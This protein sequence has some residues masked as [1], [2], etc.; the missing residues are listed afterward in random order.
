MTADFKGI[1]EELVKQRFSRS[2]KTYSANAHVQKHTAEKLISLLPGKNYN[3]ILEIGAGSGLLTE[4]IKKNLVFKKYTAVDIVPECRQYIDK[5]IPDNIFIPGNI[6]KIILKDSYDLIIS[7]AALQWCSN[8]AEQINRLKES[9]NQNG[10][11][12]A[13]IFGNSNF[14]EL[15]SVLN[16][17]DKMKTSLKGIEE[18]IKLYFDS[19]IDILKHIKYTGANSL[20][21]YKFSRTS[22]RQFETDYKSKFSKGSQVYIT[23]NP[24]YILEC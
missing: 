5:I 14:K 13:A 3:S 18:T 16:L 22:L 4:L 8:T 20:T 2:L 6:E 7:N 11:F 23:Y 15:K 17:P 19:P 1:D 24:L 21:E 9:L 10:V 12:A